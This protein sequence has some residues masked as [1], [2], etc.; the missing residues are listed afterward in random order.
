MKNDRYVSIWAQKNGSVAV[1][2]REF[3]KGE[4]KYELTE[5]R[6]IFRKPDISYTGHSVRTFFDKYAHRLYLATKEIPLGK[7]LID[8]DESNEDQIV[9]YFEDVVD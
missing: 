6:I 8:E 7:F 1:C 5:D 9:V 2:K 3:F 4:L